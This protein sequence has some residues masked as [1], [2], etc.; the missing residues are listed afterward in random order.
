M[1]VDKKLYDTLEIDSNA[2]ID[3]IKK[4]FKKLALVYHPD[5]NNGNDERF[6]EINSAY[7]ILGDPNTRRHYDLT[8][9][10]NGNQDSQDNP[11][12]GGG[13]GGGGV[14][15][16]F[17]SFFGGF[18]QQHQNQQVRKTKDSVYNYQ[19]SLQDLYK[20]LDTIIHIS[21]NV[22]CN[23]CNGKGG[24]NFH[25]CNS[26]NGLGF[27]IRRQ[28]QF[29]MIIQSQSPCSD[30]KATGKK[31]ETICKDC[32]GDCIIKKN[33]ELK[34]SIPPNFKNKATICFSKMSNEMYGV[35]TGDLFVIV[36]E[37]K[38]SNFTRLQND[39][40]IKIDIPLL[41]SLL[42]GDIDIPHVDGNILSINIPKGN[43]IKPIDTIVLENKGMPV[44]LSR[45]K[46]GK[47]EISFNIIFPDNKWAKKVNNIEVEKI[48]N[49]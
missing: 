43:V 5:K 25:N 28:K 2:T 12:G 31:I 8:G 24:S 10:V 39:L 6:K 18:G 15:S 29:N 13:G 11:F 32:N 3:E 44:E 22:L 34:L 16:Q 33:Q 41:T 38:H 42:G 21:R 45:D 14:F 27:Q 47:L 23:G 9:Q 35:E 7:K 37:L 26:C 49:I 40:F 4:A 30:C 46:F 19:I 1:V 48:F 36:S 20:G 17:S